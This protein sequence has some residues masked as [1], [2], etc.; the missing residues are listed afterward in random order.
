VSSS[1]SSSEGSLVA[2]R[3][4]RPHGLD[5]SFRVAE[6]R[7]EL[8]SLGTN[9]TVAGAE[10]E[11]VRRAGTDDAPIVRLAGVDGRDALE[12]LRG[13]W[14]LVPRSAA[15]PLEEDEYWAEDLVGRA[16]RD[17]ARDV[18]TVARLLAYPSCDLLEVPRPGAEPLL[19]PLVR[20]AIRAIDVEAGVIEIDLAFLGET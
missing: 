16:V 11:I 20:D 5:G 2:G 7:P 13:E 15:P 12:P 4:G 14:L 17:G 8:L 18:G 1:T 6:A 3:V 9:V 10:R 19:V